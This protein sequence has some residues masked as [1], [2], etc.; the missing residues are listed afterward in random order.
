MG[1]RAIRL[2]ES[3]MHID[4]FPALHTISLNI[5]QKEALNTYI[6]DQN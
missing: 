5:S 6:Q 4:K 2:G 3:L 1:R